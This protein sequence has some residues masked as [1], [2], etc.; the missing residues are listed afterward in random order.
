MNYTKDEFNTK[1]L[2]FFENEDKFDVTG[3]TPDDNLF[4]KG[5]L[6]SFNIPK[7][8]LF[9]EEMRGLPIELQGVNIEAFF[10]MNSI[11]EYFFVDSKA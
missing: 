9:I 11:Y 8:V 3:L 4:N 2:E 5:V 10:T 6:E 1:L 7:L